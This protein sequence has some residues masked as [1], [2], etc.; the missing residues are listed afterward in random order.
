MSSDLN[1]S[2]RI[3]KYQ[4]I[5][6]TLFQE[7]ER[8]GL[9]LTKTQLELAEE[10]GVNRQTVRH[11]LDWL[12]REGKMQLLAGRGYTGSVD[13]QESANRKSEGVP[14]VGF[15]LWTDSLAGLNIPRME[16]RLS[17]MRQLHSELA[18]FGFDLDI[19][20]VGPQRNPDL[21]KIARLCREWSGVFLEP[22]NSESELRPDHPFHS[23]RE[24]TVVIGTLQNVH[25]NSVCPDYYAAA[26]LAVE[27]FVRL[28]ARKILYT[29]RRD[30][31]TSHMFVRIA[32][33]EKALERYGDV[34]LL[35]TDDGSST[36]KAF[37]EVKRFFLEGGRCDAVLASTAY[38]SVGAMRAMA[39][40]GIRVP[41]DVQLIAIGQTALS[42]YMVP[43]PTAIAAEAGKMGREAAILMDGLIR[44]SRQRQPNILIPLHLV[45]GETTR[46]LAT[47]V[48]LPSVVNTMGAVVAHVE[49]YERSDSFS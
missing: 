38:A 33:V 17:L 26:Q 6:R 10:F 34:E 11:A 30:E 4:Q 23:M 42:A 41:D 9:R 27:E 8:S 39:D 36:E 18:H 40:L 37:S 5:G 35:Y 48:V 21:K 28:G 20:C 12:E 14:K 46:N 3:P 31:P 2:K 7:L 15:P 45:R 44:T 29:G 13:E 25:Y 43:R 49:G 1:P 22:N 24:Q 47:D 32:G 19:Q 16:G